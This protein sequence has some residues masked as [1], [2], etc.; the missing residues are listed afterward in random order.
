MCPEWPRRGF[1]VLRWTL[2]VVLAALGA[3]EAV[4]A[5]FFAT[6]R[7]RAAGAIALCL[8]LVIAIGVHTAAGEAQAALPLL[9]AL[10]AILGAWDAAWLPVEPKGSPE[11]RAVLRGF[12]EGSVPGD[13]FHHVDHVRM[14][15]LHLRCYPASE[16][17]ARFSTGLRRLAEK[18]GKPGMYHETVTC[19]YLFLINERMERDGR[20]ARWEEF[21]RRN[22]DLLAWRPSVLD[23]YYEQGELDS[24]LARAVFTLPR[25]SGVT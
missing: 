11:E 7:W 10:V 8:V 23:A 9:L 4:A 24:P 2:A 12:E 20:D 14:G 13:A 18:A 6:E 17:L 25:R 22:A 19:A 21:A 5:A 1:R 15:W 16:A 3:S